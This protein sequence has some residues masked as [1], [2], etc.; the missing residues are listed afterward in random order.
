MQFPPFDPRLA[1]SLPDFRIPSALLAPLAFGDGRP[2]PPSA[3]TAPSVDVKA[4]L[5][6]RD[7]ASSFKQSSRLKET[8]PLLAASFA[9][10]SNLSSD[11]FAQK[12]L[13][14]DRISKTSTPKN[15]ANST[16]VDHQK[17]M[18]AL[19]SVFELYQADEP[20]ARE[21]IIGQV[22]YPTFVSF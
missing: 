16:H 22:R 19:E 15:P 1:F 12:A 3:W 14:S 11:A 18:Q 20:S 21:T 2:R 6:P 8:A 7:L 9:R 5:V 4:H 17:A 13:E 10:L